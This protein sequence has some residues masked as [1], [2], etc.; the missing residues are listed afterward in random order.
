M[1][2]KVKRTNGPLRHW[3]SDACFDNRALCKALPEM[4]S[5]LSN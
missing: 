1:A 4:S 2:W 5:T 3:K